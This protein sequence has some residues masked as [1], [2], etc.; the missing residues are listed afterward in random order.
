M[1]QAINTGMM[2]KVRTAALLALLS[3]GFGWSLPAAA[4]QAGWE[5][6]NKLE[7]SEVIVEKTRV[8]ELPEANRNYEKFKIDPPEKK[9][10]Q[11][12]YRFSD[13]KI[14]DLQL[15][16]PVRVLTIKQDELPRLYGNYVKAG[17]GNYITP[18]LK[19]YFHNT[20]SSQMSYGADVSHVSSANGPVPNSGLSNS[21]VNL[22]GEMYDKAVT[23][24]GRIHYGRDRYNFYGHQQPETGVV[25]ADSIKQVFNRVGAQAYLN[26]KLDTRNPFQY[27]ANL[28]FDYL[29]D[30]YEARELDI[31]LG[32]ASFYKMDDQ[33][34]IRFDTDLSFV[35]HSDSA[36][37][38]RPYVRLKPAYERNT[39]LFH[40][41]LGATIAYT[42]DTVNVA[43]RFNIYPN[44][45]MA[46]EVVANKVEVF[47]GVS[48]DLER[49][50]LFQLTQENP[51]L[52]Q[53]I[54]VADKNKVLDVF[55]GMSG[56]L[57][58]DF[59]FTGRVAYQGYRNLY[60]FNN[61]AADSSKFDLVYDKGTTKVVNFFGDLTYNH[62]ERFRLGVKADYNAYTTDALAE[63][64]HRPSLQGHLYS[65][66]NMQDKIFFH[67]EVYYISSTF[68]QITRANGERAM[69]L[70]DD[71][72]DL[73][74]KV[75]YRFSDKFSTFVMGN[76]LLGKKYQRFVNYQHK[77]L[78]AI[79]GISYIF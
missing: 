21:A 66:Y 18:Y 31:R 44:I 28:G 19:G 74:F 7:S 37:T 64:F 9:P 42:G 79:A 54:S 12:A 34:G 26:N 11:V 46:Y 6:P 3:A 65:S 8:N 55:G 30:N 29:N 58:R 75:D 63:P 39:D 67:T 59:K 24:G 23:L 61:S 38:R 10:Q 69:R 60:F 48:G 13:Y 17:F 36:S 25:V 45:R 51:Y 20:R 68:G 4:Q 78:Q 70:T 1:P 77:G 33:A 72:V 49:I 56:N 57:G 71:I 41:T 2:K 16:L 22:H 52:N 53:N 73:N 62:S 15:S 27:Q 50:T 47:G 32:V 14:A 76:N 43:R 35:N 40:L 5:N